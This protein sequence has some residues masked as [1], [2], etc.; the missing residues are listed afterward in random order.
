MKQYFIYNKYIFEKEDKRYKNFIWLWGE[1]SLFS[2][3]KVRHF[4]KIKAND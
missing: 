2:D 3:T 4:T 1:C